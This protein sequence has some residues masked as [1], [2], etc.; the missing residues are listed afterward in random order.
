MFKL[1]LLV[2]QAEKI[3]KRTHVTWKKM[4]INNGRSLVVIKPFYC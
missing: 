3:I 4:S 2:I 1:L